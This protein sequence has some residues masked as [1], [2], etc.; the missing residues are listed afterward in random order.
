MRGRILSLYQL[1]Y[2]GTT[3]FGALAVGALA[4]TIGPRSG[5]VLGA[6]GALLAGA[7]GIWAQGRSLPASRKGP[8]LRY[9]HGA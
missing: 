2:M 7:V 1:V 8:P 6:V 9:D 5:L 3:P 4:S